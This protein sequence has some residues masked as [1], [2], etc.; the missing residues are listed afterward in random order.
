MTA[1]LGQQGEPLVLPLGISSGH[2]PFPTPFYAKEL[3]A[4][5]DRP[6]NV[7]S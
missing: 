4:A 3:R 7:N 5:D 2:N 6:Y 1:L